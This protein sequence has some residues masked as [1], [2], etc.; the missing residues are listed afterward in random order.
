LRDAKILSHSDCSMW[1]FKRCSM[2]P[3][4]RWLKKESFHAN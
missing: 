4:K 3:F 2:K 1:H